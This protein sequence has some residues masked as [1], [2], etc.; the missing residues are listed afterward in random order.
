MLLEFQLPLQLHNFLILVLDKLKNLRVLGIEHGLKLPPVIFLNLRS[1]E[2]KFV[3]VGLK[4]LIF[5]ILLG[6]SLF[7]SLLDIVL[8]RLQL[9]KQSLA[10]LFACSRSIGQSFKFSRFTLQQFVDRAQFFIGVVLNFLNFLFFLA[11]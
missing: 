1:F 6:D 9:F 7:V 10:L 11:L 4:I 2:D 5:F 3:E 8:L